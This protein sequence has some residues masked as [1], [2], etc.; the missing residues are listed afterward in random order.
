MKL[1]VNDQVVAEGPMKTQPAKFTLSGDGLCVGFDSGDAVSA[2]YKT[3]GRFHG[4]TIQ[5]V[6]VTVEKAACEDLEMEARR[7]LMRE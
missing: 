6:G 3:P 2:E 4:G 7:A 5:L 1:Y